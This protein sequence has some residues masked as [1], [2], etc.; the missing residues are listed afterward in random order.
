MEPTPDNH[1]WHAALGARNQH[2]E[3]PEWRGS[4]DSYVRTMWDFIDDPDAPPLSAQQVRARLRALK[5][6]K[7]D[8]LRLVAMA[9]SGEIEGPSNHVQRRNE[10]SFPVAA[11]RSVHPMGELRYPRN[12]CDAWKL[13]HRAYFAAPTVWPGVLIWSLAAFKPDQSIATDWAD[14]QD[15][16]IETADR[17]AAQF[18]DDQDA[19]IAAVHDRMG[20]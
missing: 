11:G 13:H 10:W 20:N 15:A 4:C 2:E 9:R 8:L 12:G 6:V 5:A 1:E 16:Q 7:A 3:T 14:R 17:S 19:V 18:I